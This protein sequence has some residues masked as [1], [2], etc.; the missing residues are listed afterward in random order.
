MYMYRRNAPI[1]Y[2]KNGSNLPHFFELPLLLNLGIYFLSLPRK[3]L[4]FSTREMD[5]TQ[6]VILAMSFPKA[7]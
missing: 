1:I 6:S 4:G 2:V 3:Y 7:F 5:W